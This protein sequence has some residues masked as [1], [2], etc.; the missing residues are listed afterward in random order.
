MPRI[1]VARSLT[2]IPGRAPS[3]G[4]RPPG[5]PFEPRCA[6][7]IAECRQQLPE[8]VVVEP[9][10]TARCLRIAESRKS[11]ATTTPRTDA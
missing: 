4:S 9:G 6:V 2:A 3:P 10:H 7:R 8:P 11:L 1:E 5:C